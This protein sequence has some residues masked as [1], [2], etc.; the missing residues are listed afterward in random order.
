MLLIYWRINQINISE[1][2]WRWNF[3][4]FGRVVC[5]LILI[6]IVIQTCILNT[7]IIIVI[8][9]NWFLRF[10]LNLSISLHQL[11]TPWMLR[12]LIYRY[13]LTLI[14]KHLIPIYIIILL[15]HTSTSSTSYIIITI[16]WLFL[17]N[18]IIII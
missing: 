8:L 13:N 18:C 17:F 14:I 4:N 16:L 2:F 1:L 12:L 10:T 6:I 15:F 9:I 7:S 11:S 5:E 3:L